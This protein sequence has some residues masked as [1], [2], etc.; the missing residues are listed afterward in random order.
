LQ[1]NNHLA[2]T[3]WTTLTNT[4]TF[5][6]TNSLNIVALPTSRTNSFFRL[7]GQ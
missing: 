2:T 1:Q 6:A 5:N 3:N 7:I 4:P